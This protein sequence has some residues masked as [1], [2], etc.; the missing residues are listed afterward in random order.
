MYCTGRFLT[1]HTV[2]KGRKYESRRT[3]RRR[4]LQ[5]SI[6]VTCGVY[7]ALTFLATHICARARLSALTVQKNELLNLSHPR[8]PLVSKGSYAYATL[9]TS[10]DALPGAFLIGVQWR[11]LNPNWERIVIILDGSVHRQDADDL[12]KVFTRLLFSSYQFIDLDIKISFPYLPLRPSHY[13]FV[14]MEPT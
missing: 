13:I 7:G 3:R 6:L 1:K 4:S 8:T 14:E 11:E 10:K 9:V 2:I 12:A 5:R